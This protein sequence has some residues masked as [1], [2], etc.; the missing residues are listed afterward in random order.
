MG[1]A[2]AAG[3]CRAALCGMGVT[4]RDVCLPGI[5]AAPGCG[6]PAQT[7]TSPAEWLAWVHH[8]LLKSAAAFHCRRRRSTMS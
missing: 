5:H 3:G 6:L 8:E 1:A 2:P 7:T 4:C